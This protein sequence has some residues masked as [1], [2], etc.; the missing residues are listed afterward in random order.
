MYDERNGLRQH[1]NDEH[2]INLMFQFSRNDI[3]YSI[4][5]IFVDFRIALLLFFFLLEMIGWLRIS[6]G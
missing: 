6:S 5:D 4:F 3:Q 1:S 2:K